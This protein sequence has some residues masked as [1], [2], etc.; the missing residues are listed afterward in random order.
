MKRLNQ[1][2]VMDSDNISKGLRSQ[3]LLDILDDDEKYI[4][5]ACPSCSYD[6]VKTIDVP[7][8]S[9]TAIRLLKSSPV[10]VSL[11]AKVILLGGVPR[12]WYDEQR[13]GLWKFISNIGRRELRKNTRRLDSYGYRLTYERKA[14]RLRKQV[15]FNEGMTSE[16][17]LEPASGE[18]SARKDLKESNTV[19]AMSLTHC[20]ADDDATEE[21]QGNCNHPSHLLERK[22]VHVLPFTTSGQVG[23]LSGSESSEGEAES[24]FL[25]AGGTAI[26][27]N[28]AKLTNST[29]PQ[30]LDDMC[31]G[32]SFSNTKNG[33]ENVFQKSG[34]ICKSI[35]EILPSFVDPTVSREDATLFKANSNISHDRSSSSDLLDD[36]S[37]S[38]LFGDASSS[39]LYEDA[40]SSD[41]FEDASSSIKMATYKSG[42]SFA[43]QA[44]PSESCTTESA[45][46]APTNYLRFDLQSIP[47]R[48]VAKAEY[49]TS[50]SASSYGKCS[51]VRLKTTATSKS[52]ELMRVL[53]PTP[54]NIDASPLN[55][56]EFKGSRKRTRGPRLLRK[57]FIEKFRS[58]ASDLRLNWDIN[59]D[60]LKILKKGELIFAEKMLVMKK[61]AVRRKEP[62]MHFSEAEPIDTRVCERWKEYVVVVRSTT[63]PELPLL[64]QF[65]RHENI[66]ETAEDTLQHR[67]TS[68]DFFL[69]MQCKVEYYNHLDKTICIQKPDVRYSKIIAEGEDPNLSSLSPLEFYILRCRTLRTSSQ[70]YEILRQS[71]GVQTRPKE[72][73]IRVPDA[74]ISVSLRLQKNTAQHL[75]QLEIKES[76]RLKISILPR[77]YKI[78]QHPLMRYIAVAVATELKK[79]GLNDVL[80]RWE[81]SNIILGC[82]FKRYDLLQWSSGGQDALFRSALALYGSHLM[83]YR[84]YTHAGR[85]VTIERSK[86][87][88]PAPIEGFLIKLA[89]KYGEER[90]VF[91]K[92][93]LQP[94]YFFSMDNLLFYMKSL[95]ATPP[96]PF[97]D[98]DE[99]EID[100][101][102]MRNLLSKIPAVYEHDP[103][104]LDLSGHIT[105]LK[106]KIEDS[107]FDKN[108]LRA[109]KSFQRRVVQVLKAEGMI[110]MSEIKDVYQE[111]VH[112]FKG[113]EIKY[114]IYNKA[115]KV[116]WQSE[117]SLN[118]TV[119]SIICITTSNDLTLKLLAPNA[120]VCQEWILRIKDLVRYWKAKINS[121]S[122]K[123]RRLKMENFKN[124]KLEEE[125][126]S[127]INENTPKWV[128][129]RGV[130]DPEIY[131]SNSLSALRPLLHKGL[132]YQKPKKHSTFSKYF[133]VLVPGFLVFYNA[134]HRSS[135]GFAKKVLN[136]SHKLT[137]PLEGCYIYS[138]A[139][140]ELDLLKRDHTFDEINPGSHS[141]PRY[142]S[143][144]WRS[145]EDETSRCF[146]LW[147]GN[148]RILGTGSG[149][150]NV[151]SGEH[152]DKLQKPENV[153]NTTEVE[154]KPLLLHLKNRLGV[155]GQSMVF[156]ARSR[157][158]RD[159][160]VLSIYYELERLSMAEIKS[161]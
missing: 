90:P 106:D 61:T 72:L 156:M 149:A 49:V 96:L 123:M 112:D 14:A 24:D 105:W 55:D 147:F 32:N 69:D 104:P 23:E 137:I 158:E 60:S 34:E 76:E 29:S 25:D 54:R 81:K 121:D 67:R 42:P 70:L 125:E 98:F 21:T 135:T 93:F 84:P 33:S 13:G 120:M 15:A 128:T 143:D 52:S 86:L 131:N 154:E 107:L 12:H 11:S 119:G 160:W 114:Q 130:T 129:D 35:D 159:L 116:F 8:K 64:M 117:Q 77:G 44:T 124:L 111:S 43:Y 68:M 51:L 134:F 65:Y 146:T 22:T 122:E 80:K 20:K 148:R 16:D 50:N 9:F 118:E 92:Y 10:E 66:S 110:D 102:E 1:K 57:T 46:V 58:Y 62:L 28:D 151:G 138:G 3:D 19:A 115:N 17:R 59:D 85:V 100:S 74:D 63:I 71:I 5:H 103:F 30:S 6:E 73:T 150:V 109:F 75:L 108:D 40:S 132:L 39:D 101:E 48:D 31:L 140:T 97:D 47:R 27:V 82:C 26:F 127:N 18:K 95:K 78:F 87:V 155:R 157:Q 37:S 145:S 99:R 88:E 79:G 136:H 94:S 4:Q 152:S 2:S 89:N 142:Y 139:T 45:A 56:T 41:L 141:L 53:T 91:H 113:S 38:D 161:A 83:E 126:E 144:G 36:A 7:K 153:P 133:V